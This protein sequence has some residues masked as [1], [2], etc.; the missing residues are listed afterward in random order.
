VAIETGALNASVVEQVDPPK[1]SASAPST[2]R[3]PESLRDPVIVIL[4]SALLV[5]LILVVVVVAVDSA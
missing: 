1:P 2:A 4:A 5:A 3:Q